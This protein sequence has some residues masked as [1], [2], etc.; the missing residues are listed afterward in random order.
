MD[1][2]QLLDAI[3]R[4]EAEHNIALDDYLRRRVSNVPPP[5]EE[6]LKAAAQRLAELRR[7]LSGRFGEEVVVPLDLGCEPCGGPG[8]SVL[9]QTES[10][11]AFVFST[12]RG[13]VERRDELCVVRFMRNKISRMGLPNDEALQSHPLYRRGLQYYSVGEV[14]NSS[15][16]REV[17]DRN[18]IT[19]PD[20]PPWK[21]RHFI[22]TLKENTFECLADDF[23]TSISEESLEAVMNRLVADRVRA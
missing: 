20:S 10:S 23:T 13:A 3:S 19:F 8:E 4:A 5:S 7:E 22:V 9:L 17:E 6:A 11:C 14:L 1:R 15:W 2:R 12:S 18:R 21:C 16:K